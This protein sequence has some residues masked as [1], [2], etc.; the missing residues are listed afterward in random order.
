MAFTA[1]WM[2]L[3]IIM[4]GEFSLDNETPT[5]YA[6]TYMCNQKKDTVNFFAEEIL[7]N[8]F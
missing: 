7:T 6:I 4:L 5:S 1:T 8:R 2:D 3:E